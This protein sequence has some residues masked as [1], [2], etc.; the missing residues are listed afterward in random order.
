MY[1][2]RRWCDTWVKSVNIQTQVDGKVP[3]GVDV[4]EGQL[5][6]LR[7][8]VLVD[9]V[10]AEGFNLVLAEDLLLAVINVTQTDVYE[11]VR[12]QNGLQPVEFRDFGSDSH[13]ERHRHAVNVAWKHWVSK[14]RREEQTSTDQCQ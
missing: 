10:H 7:D 11:L 6:D 14:G 12:S 13:E 1:T 3:V 8:T 9:F 4:V 2:H 5:D